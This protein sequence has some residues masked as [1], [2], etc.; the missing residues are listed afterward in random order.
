MQPAAA[1]QRIAASRSVA[2]PLPAI[3]VIAETMRPR[4]DCGSISSSGLSSSNLLK[5]TPS[6]PD[7][8][9]SAPS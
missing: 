2:R 4:E 1:A 3:E 9:L 5:S 8:R 7:K 6:E